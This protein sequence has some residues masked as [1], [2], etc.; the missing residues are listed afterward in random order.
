MLPTFILA[1]A[2]KCGTTSLWEYFQMHPDVCTCAVKEP[3]FFC[4]EPSYVQE[5][6]NYRSKS[7]GN[8]QKSI[9][10][11]KSLF[12]QCKVENAIGEASGN[13]FI[14]LEAPQLINKH[15]PD[16]ILLFILRDP[17][18]RIYSHYWQEI[19]VGHKLP[20]FDTHAFI[21]HV[22]SF[23][24]AVFIFTAKKGAIAELI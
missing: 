11:Y 2:P 13:Y 10:W 1:G 22:Y 12:R 23:S 6:D 15:L 14:S 24:S 21:R 18:E 9:N 19:R 4:E 5:P 8:Y 16:V 3:K 17:V 7:T 20:S